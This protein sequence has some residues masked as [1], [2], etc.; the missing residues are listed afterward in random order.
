VLGAPD[1]WPGFGASDV[2]WAPSRPNSTFD[3]FVRVGFA[4]PMAIRQVAVAET[5]NPGCLYKIIAYDQQGNKHELFED[6]NMG[7]RSFYPGSR[8][9]TVVLDEPTPYRV[10]EIKVVLHT[11]RVE[12]M[13]QLDAIAISSTAEPIKPAIAM[14]EG[15]LFPE[16]PENLG[17]NVNSSSPDML[18]MIS[19]DGRTLYFARKL[20]PDNTGNEL[21]D[22][23][24]RSTLDSNGQWTP[25]VNLGSPLNNEHHNFVSWISPDGRQ[26]VL[27]HDYNRRELGA[28]FRISSSGLRQ[29]EWS[30]PRVMEV[31]DLYNRSQF[32]CIHLDASGSVLLLALE[33]D[34]GLGGLDLYVS[35]A[36]GQN[37]WSAPLS[38]G[39]A[40]NTAGMEG[41]VFL[42]ADGKSL[43]FA[44][45]GHPGFGGYDMFLS[46]RL[47]DTWTAWS[48][49]LNLGPRINSERDEYYY[50]L[51][52]SGEYA[53][54][55]SEQGG[56]GGADLFRI[57]LPQAARPDPVTL[58]HASV[59]NQQ[60]GAPINARLRF[61]EARAQVV[62]GEGP[63]TLVQP[64]EDSPDR[65]IAE[66]DGYFPQGLD[67]DAE[68]GEDLTWMDAYPEP[69]GGPDLRGSQDPWKAPDR[70][71]SP[72]QPATAMNDAIPEPALVYRELD[73]NL[74]LVPLA[75]GNLV[76]LNG[77]YFSANKSFLLKESQVELDVVAQYL[78]TNPGV[79]VEVGGHTNSLPPEAFCLELSEARAKAVVQYLRERGVKQEQLQWKGYGKS[80]PIG[81]NATLEG[82]KQN[83]RVELK[84]L[85]VP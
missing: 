85:A 73:A 16:P 6:R 19:P 49:P 83:Q 63:S 14:V 74:A 40:I 62:P 71:A 79:R 28:E 15:D 2:A 72:I 38:L 17:P 25:A 43:Y 39:A 64:R 47:D 1:V 11:S 65:V 27:P 77:V 48:P 13:C 60:T 34:E 59:I 76:R 54:F 32:T 35:F 80:M 52:A 37:S 68:P 53:Y 5:L 33:R 75:V 8:L 67:L 31:P 69:T 56:F 55:S 30:F 12:G 81:D 7:Q 4:E 42:A 21:R 50:T 44:S 36:R 84:L 24:W 61:N 66:A 45:N 57:R 78:R 10:A 23:I 70:S 58:L 9:F 3:E 22:D 26:M 51:P 29:G 82:R 18:P 41:S 46:R 20:H